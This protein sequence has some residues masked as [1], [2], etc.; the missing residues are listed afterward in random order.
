MKSKYV[1]KELIDIYGITDTIKLDQKL[2]APMQADIGDTVSSDLAAM[3]AGF[4]GNAAALV[5]PDSWEA[6]SADL[7]GC[8]RCR[9]A[10][11]RQNI[12]FGEGDRQAELM[13]I[14]EGPGAEEDDTGRPFVGKAGQLLTK[15]IAAM[16][17][18]REE[19]FIGNIVKCRP[20]DNRQPFK[21][22]TAACIS[23]IQRQ[24]ALVNPKAIVTLGS[25]ATQALLNTSRS[26]SQLRGRWQKYKEIKVMPTFHPA[27]LLRNEGAKRDVWNDLQLVMADLGK[28]K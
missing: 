25:T 12:V 9:L 14:G 4:T 2:S 3:Q 23:F 10:E 6:I 5:S 17:Y 1:R 20:P 15:M 8:T 19:V 26:I 21:D 22:E 7:S 13:F 27:Y 11:K 24:I 16:G 28:K 18:K